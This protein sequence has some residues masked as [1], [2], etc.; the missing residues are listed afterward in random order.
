V[1]RVVV[2][3]ADD[4]GEPGDHED[5]REDH[6]AIAAQLADLQLAPEEPGEHREGDEEAFGSHRR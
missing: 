1:E 4:L 3:V 6:A 2:A 5:Q